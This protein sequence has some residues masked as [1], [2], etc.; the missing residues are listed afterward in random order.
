MSI[1]EREQPAPIANGS[2][3]SWERVIRDVYNRFDPPMSTL[4]VE[5]AAA[6]D[7]HGRA[8]YG[9]PLQPHNGRDSLRDAY[10]EALDLAVY[11]KT[12]ILECESTEPTTDAAV[13]AKLILS[14][15]LVGQYGIALR[16][17]VSIRSLIERRPS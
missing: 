5:D 13:A 14:S 6:R 2:I 17:C 16:L 12:A 4:V 11:L 15:S 7:A 3:P 8:T 10:D 9:V 1:L